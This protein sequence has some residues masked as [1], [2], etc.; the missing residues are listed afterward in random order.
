[1]YSLSR[2]GE[3]L[4]LAQATAAARKQLLGESHPDTL[5]S[6]NL[7]AVSL[8]ALGRIGEAIGTLELILQRM[9]V[10]GEA[11]TPLAFRLVNSLA[12]ALLDQGEADRAVALHERNWK[13][14]SNLLGMTH[15]DTLNTLRNLANGLRVVGDE[16]RAMR[17]LE[18]SLPDFIS[19]FG[20][21]DRETLRAQRLLALLYYS[22]NRLEESVALGT[23]VYAQMAKELGPTHTETVQ[24]LHNLAIAEIMSG[25][26][27]V[28]IQHLRDSLEKLTSVFGREHPLSRIAH[29]S[30]GFTLLRAGHF[31]EALRIFEEAPE[32]LPLPA[33]GTRG[34]DVSS[35]IAHAGAAQ[36]RYEMGHRKMALEELRDIY[37]RK[38]D[39]LGPDHLETVDTLAALADLY[40]RA[41]RRADAVAMLEEL[42]ERTEG[43]VRT[44]ILRDYQRARAV[45]RVRDDF[46]KAGYAR[47]SV[48]LASTNAQRALG[49]AE[50]AKMRGLSDALGKSF[51]ARPLS[52]EERGRLQRIANALAKAEETIASVEPGTQMQAVALA[53]RIQLQDRAMQLVGV[54]SGV[55]QQPDLN[56]QDLSGDA[57]FL[58]FLVSG[59]R[60]IAFVVRRDRAVSAHDLGRFP[61]LADSIDVVRRLTASAAPGTERVWRRKD[62][63][64]VFALARP[65]RDAELLTNSSSDVDDL[66]RR[67]VGPLLPALHGANRWVISP[68][69]PLAF[70]PFETLRVNGRALIERA[71]ISY[72]PSLTVIGLLNQR[73]TRIE[74]AELRQPFLGI[75]VSSFAT[76]QSRTGGMRWKDLP[77]AEEEVREI[78]RTF[79]AGAVRTLMGSQATDISLKEMNDRGELA[80]VR[81]IHLA[82]HAYLSPRSAKLSAL[83][84]SPS[85][86][87]GIA[88]DGV[89]SAAELAAFRLSAD[90]VVLSAC[91]TGVGQ[92]IVGEGVIGLPYAIMTAGAQSAVM[93][94]WQVVDESAAEFMVKFY[95]R[96]NN[97]MTA[98][99]ALRETKLELMR[100][101]G[102]WSA[103]RHWAPF[104]LYGAP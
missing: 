43:G 15:P 74:N 47:L 14:R 51:G 101:N 9:E 16:P 68:D 60:L 94:L 30:L 91:E 70:L 34:V 55:V 63:S 84:F 72:A 57:A 78:A 61:R 92:A 44:G 98:S 95:R 77:R 38:R 48:L 29:A 27:D 2:P 18:S 65:E 37:E 17:L 69:G 104:V 35:L 39:L 62:S 83:V 19:A 7:V 33:R 32:G 99:K 88:Q 87:D 97:G 45:S 6:L 31:G 100:S 73:A 10:A 28:G 102:P 8:R 40:D 103:P 12:N 22:M 24:A 54:D 86:V 23:P 42:V 89:I 56:W 85:T 90:L 58:S 36:A 21:G 1:M 79:P 59:D 46:Q 52:P 75:A 5:S 93:S 25:R 53:E 76:G 4:E 41:G 20:A 96:L 82:T 3:A 13:A 49:V 66:A 64:L 67:I 26:V 71:E 11:N 50:L 81:V 80:Q